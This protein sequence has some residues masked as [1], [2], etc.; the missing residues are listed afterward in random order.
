MYLP[1]V[2]I[3]VVD[4]K[5]H[6]HSPLFEDQRLSGTGHLEVIKEGLKETI[7]IYYLLD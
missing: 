5:I 2:I 7:G 6:G 1:R 3:P 4:R